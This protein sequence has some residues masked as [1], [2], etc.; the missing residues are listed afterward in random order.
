MSDEKLKLEAEIG[1]LFLQLE[2]AKQVQAK[3]AQRINELLAEL[4][5]KETQ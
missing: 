3:C 2:E 1:R 4:K 5:E